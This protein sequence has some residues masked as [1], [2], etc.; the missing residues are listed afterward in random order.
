MLRNAV[1]GVG[2][3]PDG[4]DGVLAFDL[5]SAA[6]WSLRPSGPILVLGSRSVADEVTRLVGGSI[7]STD[8]WLNARTMRRGLTVQVFVYPLIAGERVSMGIDWRRPSSLDQS[9]EIGGNAPRGELQ[10]GGWRGELQWDVASLESWALAGGVAPTATLG[11][12]LISDW[13]VH[14][15]PEREQFRFDRVGAG[16][17][18]TELGDGEGL[19]R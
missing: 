3:P 12:N 14:W 6:R 2:P 11:Q 9:F 5:L 8:A 1:L 15:F 4:V 18:S 19:P 7:T 17:A 16:V 13:I 10:M